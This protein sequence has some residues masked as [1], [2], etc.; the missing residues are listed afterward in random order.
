MNSRASSVARHFKAEMPPDWLDR[1]W[2]NEQ[3]VRMRLR[4][5]EINASV[6]YA[7][8]SINCVRLEKRSQTTSPGTWDRSA[9]AGFP[10]GLRR[11]WVISGKTQN[12]HITSA[13]PPKTDIR[14]P[15]RR[16]RLVP[17]AAVSTRTLTRSTRRRGDQHRRHVEAKCPRCFVG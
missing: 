9:L 2:E 17:E 8:F 4:P 3:Q 6:N 7:R 10:S 13:L 5:L 14:Q 11:L 12:E 16:V 15:G 1:P